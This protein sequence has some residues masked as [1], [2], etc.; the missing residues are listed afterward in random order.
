MGTLDAPDKSRGAGFQP[1]KN[2]EKT[3]GYKPAPRENRTFVGRVTLARLENRDGQ[4]CPFY[5]IIDPLFVAENS[6]GP[7]LFMV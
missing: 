6:A 5:S 2:P 4:E 3:A 1:A 7:H